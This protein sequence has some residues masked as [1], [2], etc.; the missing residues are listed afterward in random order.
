MKNEIDIEVE[1]IVANLHNKT[2]KTMENVEKQRDTKLVTTEKREKIFGIITKVS[3]YKV[4]HRLFV[5]YRNWKNLKFSWINQS[6]WNC[7]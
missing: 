7:K 6:I 5:N 1:K 2:G 4:F 3:Y